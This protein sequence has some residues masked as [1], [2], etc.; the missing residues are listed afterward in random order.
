MLDTVLHVLAAVL[1]LA[2]SFLAMVAGLGIARFPDLLARMHAATKPQV[3]GLGMLLTGLALEIR[4][5]VVIWTLVLVLLFQL[6]TAPVSAHMVG[7]AG[8]RTGRVRDDLLVVDELTDD[9]A[10][11][12]RTEHVT[13]IDDADD[14]MVQALADT[15]KRG[16]DA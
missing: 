10:A 7:R 14:A 5:G 4:T 8:Y 9:L 13:D 3:L 12:R 2:G 11:V 6:I 15:E 1:F 16:S